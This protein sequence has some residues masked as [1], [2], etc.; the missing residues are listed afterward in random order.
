MFLLGRCFQLNPRRCLL[1]VCTKD[2]AA[3][4]CNWLNRRQETRLSGIGI[5]RDTNSRQTLWN[6]KH[7]CNRQSN[8]AL[9]MFPKPLTCK[10]VSV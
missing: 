9:Y 1:S 10:V 7:G 8:L 4:Y 6:R 5:S 2:A 3:I